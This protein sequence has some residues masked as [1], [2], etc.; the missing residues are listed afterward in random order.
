MPKGKFSQPPFGIFEAMAYVAGDRVAEFVTKSVY[1]AR[2]YAPPFE[3]L[4]SQDEY[5]A[6]EEEKQDLEV[7]EAADVAFALH[8]LEFLSIAM[9]R[10][11][12]TSDAWRDFAV[13]CGE[14]LNVSPNSDP[15]GVV[16]PPDIWEYWLAV[17]R[18]AN[19]DYD[20][21]GNRTT[22]E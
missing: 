15:T 4:P 14:R 21:S 17:S 11:R 5:E 13:D 12:E 20:E 3:D 10:F 18:G 16:V 8:Q 6:A 2:G 9:G 22:Q 7:D 1:R 19:G